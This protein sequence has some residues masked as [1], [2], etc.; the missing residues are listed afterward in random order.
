V[1][2]VT[3][4][5]LEADGRV[6]PAKGE[7]LSVET[8]RQNANAGRQLVTAF[9]QQNNLPLIDP[10]QAIVQSVM[11]GNTPFM[12]YDS[13]W[14]GLGHALVARQAAQVLQASSCP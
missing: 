6:K 11:D 13:H 10:T 14:N 7:V 1:R 3:P 12:V 8:I 4:Y 2:E 5:R 9:A